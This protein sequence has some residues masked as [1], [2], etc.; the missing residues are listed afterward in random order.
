MHIHPD[1]S[2]SICAQAQF[3]DTSM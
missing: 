3:I 2:E 1:T